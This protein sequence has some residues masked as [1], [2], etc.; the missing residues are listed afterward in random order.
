MFERKVIEEINRSA[1]SLGAPGT[2][3]PGFTG[4]VDRIVRTYGA[5]RVMRA[6]DRSQLGPLQAGWV[7][8]RITDAKGGK[9]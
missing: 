6:V 1:P 5:D 9:R 4:F 2:L 3:V 8:R 7:K